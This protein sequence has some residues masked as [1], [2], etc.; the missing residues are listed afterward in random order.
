MVKV[1]VCFLFL[2]SLYTTKTFALWPNKYKWEKISSPHFV[3][4]VSSE[5]LEYGKRVSQKA[6]HAFQILSQFSEK[7]PKKTYIIVDHTKNFT[8]GSATF[9]PYP[10]IRL[11]PNAPSAF[12]TIG[13]YDDWLL[14]LLVHEYTHILSFHNVRGIYTPLRWAFGSTISPGYFMPIWYL[15]GLAV[16]NESHFTNGGRLRSSHYQSLGKTLK[17]N[18]ISYANEQETGDYPF[19][20]TP[21]IFGGWIN[22]Y[23]LTHSKK[24]SDPKTAAKELHKT[25]SKRLPF[26]INSGFNS[27]QKVSAYKSFRETFSTNSNDFRKT[28]FKKPLNKETLNKEPFLFYGERPQWSPAHK[29]LFVIRKDGFLR[30]SIFKVD[31]KFEEKKLFT[32]RQIE[33]YKV[34]NDK[35]YFVAQD[36]EE[37]DQMVFNLRTYD[38]K[39]KKI[40]KITNN[41]NI[42]NFDI[43]KNSKIVFVRK[44]IDSQKLVLA[45]LSD[46]KKT[47]KVIYTSID[48]E[49]RF[50][51]PQ[52]IDATTVVFTAKLPKKKEQLLELNFKTNQKEILTFEEHINYLSY[53]KSGG[54]YYIYEQEGLKKLSRSGAKSSLIL[55][56]GVI[57]IDIVN[58]DNIFL[59]RLE[60]EGP[61]TIKSSFDD[62][63]S[64]SKNSSKPIKIEK[65][66]LSP[67]PSEKLEVSKYSSFTKLRPNYILPTL[68]VSPYGFSGE[69]LY[70]ASTGSQDP[71]GLNSYSINAYSDS[72]SNKVSTEF[73]Y[74]SNHFRMPI[75]VYAAQ[76][77]LPLTYDIT[78][79]S[80]SASFGTSYTFNLNLGKSIS[81][82]WG[83]LWD[84]TENVS[85]NSGDLLRGGAYLSFAFK[86]ALLQ[87]RELAP[88]RGFE[89]L[90][91]SRYYVP[92]DEDYFD[93]LNL[94]LGLRTYF[95]SP[96]V[97]SH[98][99][100]FGLDGQWNDQTLPGILTPNSLNQ[101]YRN[102]ALGDFV[103][104]GAPTGSF[105]ALDWFA[106]G[107]LEYRFPIVNI[108]WGPGL[109]PGFLNRVTG[110]FTA[111]YGVI[112]GADLINQAFIDSDTALYSA[113]A[114]LVIEG[115][116]F[117]HLP[118]S[119]QIGLYQFLNKDVYD[120]S[121]E[122]F[123]GFGLSGF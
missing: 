63:K 48:M 81:L 71:L 29:S 7:H 121:P 54:L 90:I 25:F 27:S 20:G 55:P 24:N 8:N 50:D 72:V 43:Y 39:T 57:G 118:A 88:I 26:F 83:A 10:I 87:P 108:N 69:F 114:E 12:Q 80:T 3:V 97:S 102:S 105:F 101:I 117:Y 120:G 14:E 13:Q 111:D 66:N 21:Y 93:Y 42:H 107:H 98:R 64:L 28:F 92:V 38:F 77:N 78:R 31:E 37:Q 84:R 86:N 17:R 85:T 113:G 96:L 36:L 45:D 15:E 91:S 116:A 18:N 79:T 34:T 6:E 59:S 110:A 106:T 32:F 99:L 67:A 51:L 104:R 33:F 40:K 49:E 103:L 76:T 5:N 22:H 58:K 100:I 16:F 73:I 9:F 74:T 4:L 41:F 123:V 70:G 94:R 19:G 62:L 47:Q 61:V 35:V 115:K 60:N 75:S 112:S 122:L 44:Y 30:D 89:G 68:A 11:Q 56:Q 46:L 82:D 119:L 2:F 65:V 109:L 1:F 53:S 52:F 23:A 95:K